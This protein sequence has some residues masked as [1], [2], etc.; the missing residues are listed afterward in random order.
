MAASVNYQWTFRRKC[1]A[2]WA[3][4]FTALVLALCYP[5]LGLALRSFIVGDAVLLWAGAV[6]LLWIRKWLALPI[7]A[8]GILSAGFLALPGNEPAPEALRKEYVASLEK[9]LATRYI[10]GGENRFGIDCS[11]LVREGMIDA[12]AR[13]GFRSLDPQPLRTAF[14]IWWYDCTA[15]E[16]RDGFRDFTKCHVAAKN[17]NAVDGSMLAPGDLAV[18]ENGVHVLAFLGGNRW[19]E[20]DPDKHQVII[21]EVPAR[22]HWF[23]VP[24]RLL[25]WKWMK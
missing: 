13:L 24:V 12:L 15:R 19:I 2:L 10:W 17:I 11:G 22:N 6:G 21:V 4:L 25:R 20:A 7:L 8:I 1:I 18:T 3:A 16:L 23:E 9:Y 5:V 14:E